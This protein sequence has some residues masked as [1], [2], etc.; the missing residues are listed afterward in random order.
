MRNPTRTLLALLS[1]VLLLAAGLAAQKPDSAQALLRAATDKA[2][3]DG[4]LNGAIKQFQSI[5]EKFKTDRAVVATALVRMAEC[6]QKL[7]HAEARKIYERVVREYA[8][9]RD[10]VAQARSRLAVLQERPTPLPSSGIVSRQLW[11]GPQVD[12]LG[13]V[14]PDGGWLS[15]V[16]W[17]TGDLALRNLAIGDNRRVTNK[18]SWDQSTEFALFSRISPDG[19]LVVYNWMK[20]NFGW[21]VRVGPVDGSSYRVLLSTDANDDY[22]QAEAWSPDGKQLAVH[23]MTK[24][25]NQVALIAVAGGSPRVLKSFDWRVPG[26]M[27]FSP[28]GK[29]IAYDFAPA[30][31]SPERDV[32]VLPTDGGR[33]AR[34]VE[35]AAHDYLLGWMP[36]GRILFASDRSGTTDA[37][38]LAVSE[39]KAQGAPELLKK[40][41]GSVSSLGFSRAGSLYYGLRVSGPDVYTIPL[42]PQTGKVVGTPARVA[43]RFIG[44]NTDPDWSPDG[45]R[46]AY[47]SERAFRSDSFGSRVLCIADLASGLQRELPFRLGSISRLRWSPDGRSILFRANSERGQSFFVADAD[48]GRATALVSRQ[49]LQLSRWSADGKSVFVLTTEV[50]KTGQA[51]WITARDVKTGDEKELFRETTATPVGDALVND[52]AV[53]PDG[54]LLA[55]TMVRNRSKAVMVVSS[56]GGEPRE[57]FRPGSDFQIRN[58]AGLAWTPNGNEIL[59]VRAGAMGEQE[60]WAVP[61]RGGEPRPLGLS[62]KGLKAPVLHPDGRQVAFQAGV[63]ALEVWALENLLRPRVGGSILP[64]DT[65]RGKDKR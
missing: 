34:L 29:Y 27:R 35:H 54:R 12:T 17:E 15:F 49:G 38:T 28:D 37:W 14:S 19:R 48:T 53:S 18:G 58:F 65:G 44:T 56:E 21:E 4:D 50:N 2:V 41:L 16:D 64:G 60:L 26:N 11:T 9:Q 23:T 24:D 5:V 8:D 51:S 25:V 22:A 55:F 63:S 20:K 6:Y 30:E 47:V 57:I 62:M 3:V 32:Y 42:D 61:A 7:G 1:A 36:D 52:L 45:R 46:L 13:S 39:G 43:Q 31:N 59:L 33:E 40:D 10:P